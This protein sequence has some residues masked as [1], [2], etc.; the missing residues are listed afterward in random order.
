MLTLSEEAGLSVYHLA[1]RVRQAFL[2]LS[3]SELAELLTNIRSESL[4]RHLI[5]LREGQTDVIGLFPCPLTALPDQVAY[6]HFVSQTVQNALKRL[7][8]LYFQDFAVREILRLPPEEEEWLLQCWGPSQRDN[9]PVFGRLD[10]VIDF[11]NPMWK[12]SLRFMEPNMS[13]IGGINLVPVAERIVKEVVVPKLTAKDPQLHFELTPDIREL[14]MQLIRDHLEA[15]GRPTRNVCFVEPKYAG[16]GIDEQQDVARFFHKHYGM[17]ILHADP[18][19]LELKGHE[20]YYSGEPIDLVYRDYSVMDLLALQRTGVDVKPMKELFRQNRV[21][22]SITAELDQKACF[23]VLTSPHV[24]ERFFSADERQIFRRHVL[25][26]RVVSDR[27]TTLPDGRDAELLPFIRS[28]RETLVLKP[29]R[30]YGGEGVF[31]GPALDQ[32]SWE[33][34]IEKAL[35]DPNRW[36]VQKLATIPISEFPVIASDGAIH[37]EPFHVVMGF[38]PTPYGVAILGRASQ[39]QVVNVAQRGGMCVIFVG[40]PVGRLLGPGATP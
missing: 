1:S 14:L 2:S 36:V 34:V 15:I 21:V 4:A 20:V 38:A 11:T 33:E 31:L 28:D 12:N 18:S 10:A 22:S 37:I 9:N 39:K 8:E 3:N 30:A 16:T 24:A 40:R 29:N 27:R 35:A 26:T 17:K 32:A 5:Y 19:E 23:E 13:G 25:W 6:L 7:P